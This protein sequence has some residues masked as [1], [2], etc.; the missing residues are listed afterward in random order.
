MPK[1]TEHQIAWSES[2]H[3][4]ILHH[5]PSVFAINDASLASWLPL[6]DSFHL[7]TRAGYCLTARRETK[8]RGGMYWYAYKRV[9]TKVHKKYLGAGD[10]LTLARLEAVAR[11]FIVAPTPEPE[12][13]PVRQPPPAPRRPTF[14]FTNTRASALA[15]FGCATL[16]TKA[17]L[18]ARYRTLSKQYHPD[19][20][21]LHQDMVAINLAYDYLKRYF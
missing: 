18:L 13:E 10:K 14:I 1:G 20:G 6:I 9:G 11:A 3:A 17:V 21:G 12:P 5:A 16:P 2:D 4:Y 15:I 7:K 19:A 8:T